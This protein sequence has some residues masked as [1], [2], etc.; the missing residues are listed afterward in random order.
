MRRGL[1][2]Q[3]CDFGRV[4]F[5]GALNEF[6]VLAG[7]IAFS[8]LSTQRNRLTAQFNNPDILCE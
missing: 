8:W 3:K 4:E 6:A 2:V 7:T 5:A 1:Q